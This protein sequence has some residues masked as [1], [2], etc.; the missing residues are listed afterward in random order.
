M[1]QAANINVEQGHRFVTF[2]CGMCHAVGRF[3]DSPLSIAPPFRDLH[4]S[5]PIDEL[6]ESLREG[7][8]F[9]SHPNMP[10]FT[11]EPDQI[12]DVIA[13]LRSLQD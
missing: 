4:R 13:Y 12:A 2:H 3:G 7:T 6:D 5:Y 8:F 10:Q 9:A 1:V 11:L